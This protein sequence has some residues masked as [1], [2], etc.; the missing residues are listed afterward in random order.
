MRPPSNK[1]LQLAGGARLIRNRRFVRSRRPRY[2]ER[3]GSPAGESPA[4]E[5]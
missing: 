5:R 2:A 3:D 1:A 4:A